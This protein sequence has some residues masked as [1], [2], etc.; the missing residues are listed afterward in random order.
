MVWL[1]LA[2]CCH[3]PAPIGTTLCSVGVHQAEPLSPNDLTGGLQLL[4]HITIAALVQN[5]LQ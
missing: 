3:L 4:Y 2:L 5:A 1:S